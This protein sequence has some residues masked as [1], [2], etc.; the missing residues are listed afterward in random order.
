[1]PSI[2]P[3][4]DLRS[5][6]NEISELCHS[7]DEPVYITKGGHG[8]LAVMSVEAY[9]R[10]VG[11]YELYKLIDEGMRDFRDHH[12]LLAEDVFGQVEQGIERVRM[13]QTATSDLKGIVAYVAHEL[14]GPSIAKELVVNL[15]EVVGGLEKT[16]AGPA[17]VADET[18]AM[19][20]IRK[21]MVDNCMM[22]YLVAEKETI[23]TVIRIL[24]GKRD[25]ANLL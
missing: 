14:Q 9:E 13:T 19:Q 23:V 3:S 1:M 7:Y 5:K 10:L 4:S 20:G 21:S 25:W 8:D 16:P 2:R 11:K 22:F 6:Y 18:L 12:V 17:I 24:Y 15:K